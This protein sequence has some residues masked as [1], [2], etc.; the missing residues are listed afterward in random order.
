[1]IKRIFSLLP[2]KEAGVRDQKEDQLKMNKYEML[3]ILDAKLGDEAVEA[4]AE[5]YKALV[6]SS[7]GEVEKTDKWGV[8]K[9]A[10]PIEKKS[11]GFYVLTTFTAPPALPLE[12]ER[13]MRV[14]DEVIRFM[15]INKN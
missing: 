3:Y 4:Q 13:Q 7:G 2:L 5:K 15:I 9:F 14:S 12:I 1:M 10:Y 11:E 8:K 6:T